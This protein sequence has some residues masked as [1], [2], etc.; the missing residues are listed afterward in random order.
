V[1]VASFALN[2][3]VLHFSE[4][5]TSACSDFNSIFWGDI[6]PFCKALTAPYRAPDNAL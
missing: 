6:S 5:S 2:R 3:N 4:S 1:V